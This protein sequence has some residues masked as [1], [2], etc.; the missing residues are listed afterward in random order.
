M[1]LIKGTNLFSGNLHLVLSTPSWALCSIS[2]HSP[3]FYLSPSHTAKFL[4]SDLQSL[5]SFL[6]LRLH[7][8]H[9]TLLC[10]MSCTTSF[11]ISSLHILI[12]PSLY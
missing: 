5:F 9:S 12:S 2:L 8:A 11:A 10:K 3:N 4:S 7:Y 6:L 1:L